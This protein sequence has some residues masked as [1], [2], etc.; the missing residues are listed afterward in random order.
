M[1]SGSREKFD[2]VVVGAGFAG[3]AAAVEA[4]RAGASVLVLEKTKAPG[5]NSI[6]SDG[7]IAAPG[8]DIQRR[9]GVDD[10]PELMMSDMM[11]AGLGLNHPELV[12]TVAQGALDAF[13][14]TAEDLGVPYLDRVDLF[15]GHSVARSHAPP[16]ISGG[17]ILKPLLS[18]ARE[19]GVE[20]RTAAAV[21]NLT[22]DDDRV[23][24]VLVEFA[25]D[26]AALIA[27]RSAVVLAAGGYGADVA[28][29]S[30]QDPRLGPEI[31]TTNKPFATAEVLTA[32]M[33]L[34]AM[35]VHLCQIQL[36]PWA[37]PDEK[38]FGDG[39]LFTDYIGFIHGIIVHPD[40]ASRFVD[41]RADRK[42]VS[43]ALLAVGRPAVCIADHRA[44]ADSGWDLS[45]ALK[46]SVVRT[47]DSIKDL[48]THYG[49]PPENLAETVARAAEDDTRDD[50]PRIVEAP[51]YGMRVWPKVH[52]CMGGL[53]IDPG[54]RVLGLD[55]RP[56]PGL[57][58]AGE[59][60][61]GVHGAS[62]LGSCAITDCLVFGRIAGRNASA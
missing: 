56:M 29:R 39:P 18:R 58:A 36:G 34:G 52:Y 27:A 14:W 6:I 17:S 62:R 8:T 28:F 38:G 32:A 5:G 25:D 26:P 44:V 57:Y 10:S 22:W 15:G 9:A 20:I 1:S 21:R 30:A 61:G 45:K 11:R 41:E 48:A 12:R 55:H 51:F 40:T 60:T 13:R 54:A 7:G 19:T 37:S 43:D 16:D 2:V 47:F 23:S 42:T 3:L 31:D 50:P 24:G 35:P 59:V 53:R 46:K 4:R 33:R 49:L